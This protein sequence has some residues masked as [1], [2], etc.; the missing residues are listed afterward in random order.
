M[1]TI[2]TQQDFIATKYKDYEVFPKSGEINI[3]QLPGTDAKIVSKVQLN[4]KAGVVLALYKTQKNGYNW[5]Y[6]KLTKPVGE[7]KYGFIAGDVVTFKN[8]ENSSAPSTP[9]DKIMISKCQAELNKLLVDQK[10][11]YAKL[12]AAYLLLLNIKSGKVK[13]NANYDYQSDIQKLLKLKNQ[14]I[15]LN[16]EIIKKQEVVKV[17]DITGTAIK[18]TSKQLLITYGENV[19]PYQGFLHGISLLGVIIIA[20]IAYASYQ[21]YNW[22]IDSR[23]KS[24]N[25]GQSVDEIIKALKANG[26]SDSVINSVKPVIEAQ[27]ND[28]FDAGKEQGENSGLFGKYKTPLIILGSAALFFMILP[29]AEKGKERIQKLRKKN[30]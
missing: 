4:V 28:T 7:V 17:V 29:Y 1:A 15:D 20:A 22:I 13:A 30:D 26:V 27:L 2:P 19:K 24:K 21:L 11:V 18:D 5:Y 3:R 23:E 14:Y 16:N 9:N 8:V 10:N 25:V 12:T 6:I